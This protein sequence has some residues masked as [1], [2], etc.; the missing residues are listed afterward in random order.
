MAVH[1]P[2][3]AFPTEKV[4]L[5]N[6]INKTF[7]VKKVTLLVPTHKY[8]KTKRGPIRS[9]T[10]K[11]FVW[12][13]AGYAVLAENT[14]LWTDVEK[15][16]Y[17]TMRFEVLTGD[18]LKT[19]DWKIMGNTPTQLLVTANDPSTESVQHDVEFWIDCLE[20]PN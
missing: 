2:T 10:A 18:G 20:L 13:G 11:E 17:V 3:F 8:R 14:K 1:L 15:E 9:A 12:E 5:L 6:V 7:S 16:L 19:L 4:L